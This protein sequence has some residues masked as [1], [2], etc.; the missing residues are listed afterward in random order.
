MG[1]IKAHHS[2]I[3]IDQA[4]SVLELAKV[5]QDFKADLKLFAALSCLME[6]V[7]DLDFLLVP[8]CVKS[9]LALIPPI[10][11]LC[12]QKC[13]HPFNEDIS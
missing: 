12:L 7:F 6:R 3:T 1:L 5:T 10:W 9:T 8:L 4:I 11:T 13:V 2:C